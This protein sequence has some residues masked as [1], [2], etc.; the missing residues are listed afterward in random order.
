MRG[1]MKNEGDVKSAVKDILN[2]L[3]I[4]WY[5]PVQTGYGVKGIPDFVCCAN[6]K[7]VGIETKFK[8]NGLSKWQ[9]I[10]IQRIKDSKGAVFVI[11][12]NNLTYLQEILEDIMR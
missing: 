3:G 2:G 7:F 5:M 1:E 12:E 6:G 8:K 11:N 10:Q 9:E 4:W